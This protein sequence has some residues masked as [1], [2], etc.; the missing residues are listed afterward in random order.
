MS[1]SAQTL[2]AT[3]EKKKKTRTIRRVAQENEHVWS[4]KRKESTHLDIPQD[5][6]MN[7]AAKLFEKQNEAT[8]TTSYTY[9]QNASIGSTAGQQKLESGQLDIERC[10]LFELCA[11]F[12]ISAKR[13]V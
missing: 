8:S 6:L 10:C 12:Q 1:A 5:W 7:F 2:P 13:G 9:E 3:A 11:C 4:D